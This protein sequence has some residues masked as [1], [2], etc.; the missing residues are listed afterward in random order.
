[1]S[2]VLSDYEERNLGK[3][4]EAETRNRCIDVYILDVLTD[5]TYTRCTSYNQLIYKQNHWTLHFSRLIAL[6]A[7]ERCLVFVYGYCFVAQ[8]VLSA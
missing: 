6:G 1:M 3:E 4:F 5:V 2:F 7:Q 8:H